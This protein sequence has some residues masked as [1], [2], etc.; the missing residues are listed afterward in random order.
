[1]K[2]DVFVMTVDATVATNYKSLNAIAINFVD[3]NEINF[4]NFAVSNVNINVKEILSIDITI[5]DDVDTRIKF[6]N[7]IASYSNLWNDNKFIMQILSNKWMSIE[8]KSNVKIET[9]KMYSLNL[10]D[11]KFVN[12]TFDK[13]HAQKQMKY[14]NQ[15]ISYDYLVF[16]I[17]RIVFSL[18]NS[19]RKK[20]VI[21]NIRDFNKIIFIDLYFMSLQSNIIVRIQISRLVLYSSHVI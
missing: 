21:V 11:K 13:L 7:V 1:M 15:F 10:V 6:A 5:Y 8:F 2:F 12:E 4:N 3:A 17:W 19:K 20:R 14:I 16:A 18:N 9:T